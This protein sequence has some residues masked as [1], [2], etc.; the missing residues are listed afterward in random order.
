MGQTTRKFL[1]ERAAM[2]LTAALVVPISVFL[3]TG[4]FLLST[5]VKQKDINNI[6]S[7]AQNVKFLESKR[8]SQ[9]IQKQIAITDTLGTIFNQD[10][11]NHFL[12][13]LSR[14]ISDLDSYILL[15]PDRIV[16]SGIQLTEEQREKLLEISSERRD[17]SGYYLGNGKR[18]IMTYSVMNSDESNPVILVLYWNYTVPENLYINTLKDF[19]TVPLDWDLVK[20][21]PAGSYIPERQMID[22]ILSS[23]EGIYI[24]EQPENLLSAN[25]FL[26]DI[27]GKPIAIVNMQTERYFVIQMKRLFWIGGLSLSFLSIVSALLLARK[28]ASFLMNPVEKLSYEMNRIASN[29]VRSEEIA[30]G[31]YSQLDLLV[32]SFNGILRSFKEYYGSVKKYETIVTN[33][34]EGIF[35][36]DNQGYLVISNKA[37]GDIFSSLGTIE[38]L[39]QIWGSSPEQFNEKIS[40]YQDGREIEVDGRYYLLFVNEYRQDDQA[41]YLGLISE[42]T[43]QREAEIERQRLEMQLQTSKKL[44]EIGLLIEGISHNLNS[45]LHNM[46]A[47]VHFLR[48]EFGDHRDLMKLQENGQ[49]MAEI[50]KSLMN[51]M[52]EAVI[53]SARPI[54]INELVKLELAFFDHNLYFKNNVR[55]VIELA[56]D[57]PKIMAVY[58]DISQA[59]SNLI[60]NAVDAVKTTGEKAITIQTFR[61]EQHL[62]IAVEDTGIGIAQEDLANIFEPFHSSKEAK[63]GMGRGIGLAISK[64]LLESYDANITV[65]STLHI[66]SRFEIV[67]PQDR[68]VTE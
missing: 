15:T 22:N 46:L 35:W 36:S 67:F 28:A 21:A 11:D 53:F 47:Y 42:I 18:Y 30:D 7:L 29:P 59:L 39:C 1:Q 61:R 10:I 68:F 49:R 52:S 65:E 37:F 32:S 26:E 24:E 13:F 38:N 34:K 23:P 66:G 5:I 62:I 19:Q 14:E 6:R 56:D 27:F 44:A 51:R 63:D 16:G 12:S 64:Q 45:P 40:E 2:I 31:H 54:E 4:Y 43:Q 9:S 48:T 58:S 3:V 8:T 25:F 20:S 50:I 17:G 41:N 33:I 60:S 55:K 57:L